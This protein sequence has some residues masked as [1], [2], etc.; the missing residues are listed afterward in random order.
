MTLGNLLHI[1]YWLDIRPSLFS[2][3]A[4]IIFLVLL[5]VIIA[6][7]IVARVM[8]KRTINNPPLRRFWKNIS[9]PL[10]G[11]IITGFLYYFFRQEGAVMLSM[12]LLGAIVG[13][14]FVAWGIVV[15]VRFV[16]SYE[17]DRKTLA[18]R[19]VYEHY[20]PKT[21]S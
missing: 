20:L 21:R 1:S 10:L 11:L 6:K 4:R 13:A 3:T 9:R 8:I 7:Y 5:G 16:R 19:K 14:S 17:I 18:E 12:R 15:L 2:S